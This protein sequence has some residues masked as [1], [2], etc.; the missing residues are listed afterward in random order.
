MKKGQESANFSILI[1]KKISREAELKTFRQ[2][3]Y[4]T[5]TYIDWHNDN[6]TDKQIRAEEEKEVERH[7]FTDLPF[8]QILFLKLSKIQIT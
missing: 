2:T 4:Q 7:V 8:I 6:C 3:D 1:A 5:N